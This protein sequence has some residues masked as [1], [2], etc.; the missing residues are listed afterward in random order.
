MADN[1][2]EIIP[3]KEAVQVLKGIIEGKYDFKFE[4]SFIWADKYTTSIRFNCEG[5]II[6]IF[7]D[8][9]DLDYVDFITASD[10]REGKYDWWS[11]EVHGAEDAIDLLSEEEQQILISKFEEKSR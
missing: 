3:P 6:Q 8:T 10:G 9:G 1:K 11:E 7:V 4:P 5:Y 2:Q